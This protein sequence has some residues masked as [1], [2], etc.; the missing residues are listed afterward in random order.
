M[1]VKL[2]VKKI[3]DDRYLSALLDILNR[4]YKIRA[5]YEK[6]RLSRTFEV[7]IEGGEEASFENDFRAFA[8]SVGWQ[9][10]R[11]M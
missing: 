8:S 11:M 9:V 5:S 7:R 10:E 2:H 6:P 3:K 1:A 4:H